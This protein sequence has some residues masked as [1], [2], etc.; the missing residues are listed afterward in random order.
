MKIILRSFLFLLSASVFGQEDPVKLFHSHKFPCDTADNTIEIN[1]CS[2]IKRDFADSLLNSVYNEIINALKAEEMED[3]NKLK[4]AL[5]KNDTSSIT[6][7]SIDFIKKDIDYIRKLKNKIVMSQEAW[8]KSRD[9][10]VDVIVIK[11]EGGTGFV[12]QENQSLIEDT[13]ERIEKLKSF[14]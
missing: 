4:V 14:Y 10:N 5:S 13:L 11:S 8:I 3:E 1:I 9:L 2:G 7:E 12:A 6:K